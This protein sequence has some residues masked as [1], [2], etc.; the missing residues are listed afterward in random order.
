RHCGGLLRDTRTGHNRLHTLVGLL[1]QS[2]FGRL[3]GYD[4]VNDADRLAL[5][6]VMRQIVGGQ[7]RGCKGRIRQSDGTV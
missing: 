2:V 5:D 7:S 6:L 1:R 3:A 4:D